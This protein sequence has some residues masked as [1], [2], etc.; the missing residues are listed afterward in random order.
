MSAA[1]KVQL[2]I[3]CSRF[4]AVVD[5]MAHVV[6]RTAHT[7]FV[8]ETQD[9]G[10]VLVSPTGE[11][12]AAPRRYGVTNMI[13]MPMAEAIRR[14]GAE[15]RDGD[16]FI[17]NDP[18]STMGMSTH[19]S[20]VFLW[21][22]VFHGGEIVCH[23]W[24]F[25]HM[26][27]V[28][29]RV[30]GSIAPSSHE[31]FQEGIRVPPRKLYHQ[32]RLD[33]AFLDLF[34]CNTRTPRQNW[35]DM[36]ACLAGLATAEQRLRDLIA[37]YGFETIRDGIP[38]VLDYAEQQSRRI[39]SHV[40][41]GVYRFSDFIEADMVGLGLVRINLALTVTG[42]E[43]L[44]DFSGTA[45]QVR[46]ALNLPSFSR[47]GHWMLITPL[48]SWLCTNDP[49]IAYNAGLTR[50]FKIKV[51]A[52][53]L[54]NPEPGAAYGARY[55]TSHKAGDVVI[56]ALAQ[57][58][59]FELPA[60]DSGQ[61]SILLV[62]VP[63]LVSGGTKV[64]VIQPIVGGSGGRPSED[65]VDG[66]MVIL[67]FLKNIPTEVFEREM[68]EILIRH[69]GLRPDSGGA[70][71]FR[72]GTGIEIEFETA[73]AYTTV[74]SR[75]M[76]RYIFPPPGR[77]GGLPGATGYTLSR[78]AGGGEHD[79]G[80]IDVVQMQPGDRLL[81]GTQGGGGFGDPL[82]RPA[83][84]VA[85]DVA[86]GLVSRGV[87]ARNY[88]VI[89]DESGK[90]DAAASL[91]RRQKLRSERGERPLPAFSFGP[92][93]DRHHRLWTDEIYDSIEAAVQGLP[94]VA[95]QL[96]YQQISAEVERLFEAKTPVTAAMIAD[97]TRA[98]ERA[99]E[100]RFRQ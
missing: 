13:G 91:A 92:A 83:E 46:A 12:F 21:K 94:A 32:G 81:I 80:K 35:G 16:I 79:I 70:G 90:L 74:T 61:G 63:D 82:D 66:T 76:E 62:S 33:Q 20:D 88:G 31:I 38:Q 78:P 64:S 99:S 4:Q 5:E 14:M 96:R 10:T 1:S 39:I 100:R 30:P 69:Y 87:A 23:A 37:R 45:P 86:N 85:Y 19:L 27:D 54:L 26:S 53:T 6:F 60:T 2:E 57:A 65:G 43:F 8:K 7:V 55:A 75:C 41:D 52:G 22:P 73:A 25:I 95:R 28:G 84:Q 17:A 71:R 15:V 42:G 67:N 72:G 11:I 56:G 47:N 77:M 51:P 36:K 50:P 18:E 89:V 93:R 34:L 49:T 68:P 98:L 40:P 29:G 58:V 48:V 24:T 3:L 59:P 97:L 44:L 9:Y